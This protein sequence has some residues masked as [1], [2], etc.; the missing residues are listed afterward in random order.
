MALDFDGVNDVVSR[1]VIAPGTA[2]TFACWFNADDQGESD[3]GTFFIYGDVGARDIRLNWNGTG[4]SKKIRFLVEWSGAQAT[5]DMTTGFAAVTGWKFFGVSYDAGDAANNPTFYT[6]DDGTAAVL[7]VG[8]GI[9]EV[10]SPSGSEAIADGLDFHVGGTDSGIETSNGRMGEV[11]LWTS[12]L[13][14]VDL[15]AIAHNGA[16]AVP[17]MY[18]YWPMD[19]TG[20]AHAL[21]FSGNAR[22]GT[23]S[24]AVVAANPPIRPCGRRG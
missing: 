7:T 21:D 12:A 17:G 23:I 11:A 24:G 14:A 3:A 1:D 20:A 16:M 9:T 2:F 19:D 18:L 13:T 15:A 22:D 4:A 6:I 5:W 10:V 8:S